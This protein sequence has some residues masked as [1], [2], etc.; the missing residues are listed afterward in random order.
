MGRAGSA[1]WLGTEVGG[2]GGGASLRPQVS[3]LSCVCNSL[4]RIFGAVK[5]GGEGE[6]VWQGVQ[7]VDCEGGRFFYCLFCVI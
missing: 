2:W 1:E 5:G 6:G 3:S 7:K 4:I